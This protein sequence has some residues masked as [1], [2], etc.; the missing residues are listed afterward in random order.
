MEAPPLE[1]KLV[2]IVALL[3]LG[4]RLGGAGVRLLFLRPSAMRFASAL[5]RRRAS[6]SAAALAS[7]SSSARAARMFSSRFC[8]RERKLPQPKRLPARSPSRGGAARDFELPR[9]MRLIENGSGSGL[10]VV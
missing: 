9:D 1:R 8:H 6:S 7:A 3:L 2:A 10:R 4:S 5:A